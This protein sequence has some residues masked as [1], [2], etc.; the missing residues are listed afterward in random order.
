MKLKIAVSLF[1][2]ALLTIST[3]ATAA[4][5]FDT[6][7][8]RPDKV[9]D[10]SDSNKILIHMNTKP[11]PDQIK[12]MTFSF[13]NMK[14]EVPG[15]SIKVIVHGD[16]IQFFTEAKSNEAFK[17]FLDEQRKAG[18]QFLICNNTLV[19]KKM[20]VSDLYD[21]KAADFVPAALLKIARLQKQGY[22][23]IKLF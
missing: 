2:S 18:V 6:G 7:W 14:K 17:T 20:K 10:Y 22:A 19:M 3:A 1:F 5:M 15:V 11:N 8:S 23:Y 16:A 21:V 12:A 4:E 9:F 13:R